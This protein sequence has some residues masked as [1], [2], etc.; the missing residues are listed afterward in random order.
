MKYI[1]ALSFEMTRRCNLKCKWCSKGEPQNLDITTEIIDKTLNEVSDYY[2]NCIRIT[3]GEP[4][5]VPELV[6]YLIDKII[7]KQIKVEMIH[8]NTNATI[9]NEK[10][11]SAFCRFI[12]YGKTIQ[13][14]RTVIKEYFNDKLLDPQFERSK[15]KNTMVALCLST[16]E[17][18]NGNTINE[19]Y[20]FYNVIDSEYFIVVDQYEQFDNIKGIITIEGLAEQ[21]YKMFSEKELGIIRIIHN[22][23]C[24][25]DDS[26]IKNPCIKKSISVGANG[27]IYV[28][29]M[30]SYEH[31]E[32]DYLFNIMD[33]NND[34]W[35]KVDLWCWE[36][37]IYIKAN[38]FIE[39]YKAIHWQ[40]DNGYEA[41]LPT[42]TIAEAIDKIKM[43]IDT[44]EIILKEYHS[45]LPH[46]THWELNLFAV[47]AYCL[48]A[49]EE[50]VTVKQMK[51]FVE[52]TTGLD[53]EFINT[54]NE[55]G[56]QNIYQNMVNTNNARAVET[57]K[58]P[59]I[60]GIYK[61]LYT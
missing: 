17:H 9:K 42:N 30:L 7:E 52:Y 18:D 48:L 15:N 20:N 55:E 13:E 8:I 35:N 33:C 5:L 4:F 37:P 54:M 43:Q 10:I 58:N 38:N 11:R 57:I 28:G 44:Y 24:I 29:C 2:I 1:A 21:N 46:L 14:E 3:G 34:F 32:K 26:D 19:V 53:E 49:F 61:L 40:I 31:I 27:K 59:W 23:F 47:S 56:F 51:L 22:K 45:Q 50:G 41:M 6:V 16:W 60:K 12:E 25:I 36:N 39:I